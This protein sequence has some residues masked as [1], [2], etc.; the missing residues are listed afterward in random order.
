MLSNIDLLYILKA[1]VGIWIIGLFEMILSKV[2]QDRKTSIL[3]SVRHCMLAC[4]I[5]RL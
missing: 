2:A 4:T 5:F 1:V 3:D